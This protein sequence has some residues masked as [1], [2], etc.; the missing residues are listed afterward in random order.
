MTTLKGLIFTEK[1]LRFKKGEV[2]FN[3]QEEGK[4]MY[5]IDSGRVKIV[6]NTG[7]NEIILASLD[8]GDFFGEMSLIT[9][10]KRIASAIALTDCKLNTMDKKTFDDN[11]INDKRFMRNVVEAQA[12]RLE[13][14]GLNLKR[15]LQ[16]FLRMTSTFNI[17]G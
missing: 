3:N 17:T 9:G 12:S 11:L 14:T 6:M 10:N 13:E 4:E 16:R 15:H 1:K 8:S 7:G 2:I 5:F